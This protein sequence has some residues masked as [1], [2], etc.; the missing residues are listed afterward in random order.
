MLH[1][2]WN[3][4]GEMPYRF[5]RS[6]VKFQIGRFR[7]IGQSQLSNPSDLPCCSQR[8]PCE[9]SSG[10]TTHRIWLHHVSTMASQFT[11]SM[12]VYKITCSNDIPFY[13][14][15]VRGSNRSSMDNT[16]VHG[17]RLGPVGPRW[18]PCWPHEPCYQGRLTFSCVLL[19]FGVLWYYRYQ[20]SY[21]ISQEICTRLLLCC[22]LL[23]LYIDWFS[24]IH[25][26]YFTGTVAI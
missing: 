5:P 23:W 3:S 13:W 19:W 9:I 16:P 26:A 1:K 25:Q 6:S 10:K 14:P 12:T 22:A 15:F 2:A 20:S 4:K 8:E 7:T 18:A 24:H 17:A 11:S 21:S